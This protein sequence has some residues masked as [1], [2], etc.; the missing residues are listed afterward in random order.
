MWALKGI[1]S[2]VSYGSSCASDCCTTIAQQIAQ[3]SVQQLHNKLHNN[4]TTIAKQIVQQL[5]KIL[6]N[7]KASCAASTFEI[8]AP[9]QS[10]LLHNAQCTMHNV[11][12]THVPKWKAR[13]VVLWNFKYR[14]I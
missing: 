1:E 3:Q 13:I 9:Q 10:T 2:R 8:A 4:C 5:H 11:Q 6:Y 12:C 14:I 7:N